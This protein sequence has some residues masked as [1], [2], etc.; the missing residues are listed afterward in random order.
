MSRFLEDQIL[1]YLGNKLQNYNL[2]YEILKDLA[3]KSEGN[4]LYIHY[5][6]KFVVTNSEENKLNALKDLPDFGGEIE[7][8]YRSIW[9][10][11]RGES[12][13]V[14]IISILARIRG[15]ISKSILIK[16]LD[17]DTQLVFDE[18]FNNLKHLLIQK[19]EV[20]IY[21]NSFANFI[22]SVTEHID[23][24]IQRTISDC[25]LANNDKYSIE[26]KLYHLVRSDDIKINQAIRLCNQEF[27]DELALN[28]VNPDLILI[29]VKEVLNK[30]VDLMKVPDIVRILLLIQRLKF[31]NEKVFRQ[32]A[33]EMSKALLEIGKKKESLQYIIREETLIIE[34]DEALYILRRYLQEDE[35][36][37]A[38]I[39]LKAIQNRCI[40]DY[41]NNSIP[42]STIIVDIS[43]TALFPEYDLNKRFNIFAKMLE[44]HCHDD[45]Y[46]IM[47]YISSNV[48]GY[49][50][51]DKNRYLSIKQKE[52]KLGE[53]N[54]ASLG[55]QIKL[56]QSYI[57]Y[58][59]QFYIKDSKTIISAVDD[60][61]KL[62]ERFGVTKN[63]DAALILMKFGTDSRLINVLLGNID[64]CKFEIR[65]GNGV[66][67]NFDS[68]RK[69]FNYYMMKS[70]LA[71]DINK[72]KIIFGE[73]ES[74][75]QSVVE[76]ISAISGLCWKALRENNNELLNNVILKLN[77]VMSEISISL[78][79]RSK[80]NRS[81][82]LPEH[83]IPFVWTEIAVL[84][85]TFN[86]ENIDTLLTFVINNE[87]LG[88]YNEGYRRVL[89]NI[90]DVIINDKLM[91]T[92]SFE[93]LDKLEY[94]TDEFVQNR[95]EKT[96]DYLR[97]IERYGR[98]GAYERARNV[99]IKMLG[100]SM[101]PSWYKEAQMS[102]LGSCIQELFN[103]PNKEDYIINALSNLDYSS[104]EMTFQRYIRDEKENFVGIICEVLGLEVA[105]KYFKLL[106]FPKPKDIL[107][108]V[109]CMS[110]DVLKDGFGY[111]QGTKEI[112]LQDGVLSLINNFKGVSDELIWALTE[113]FIQG[114]DRYFPEYS[115][116]QL[117]TIARSFKSNKI[118]YKE[119]SKRVTRQFVSE[120]DNTRRS[121]YLDEFN[122]NKELEGLE[123]IQSSLTSLNIV[124]E[125]E[126]TVYGRYKDDIDDKTFEGED[127]I[128]KL[129]NQE[130]MMGNLKKAKELIAD[131]LLKF[132]VQGIS[133]FNYSR[134]TNKYLELLKNLVESPYELV[135]LLNNI[136]KNPYGQL[137]WKLVENMLELI[138][139]KLNKEESISVANIITEHFEY[140]L[141]TPESFKKKYEW[142]SSVEKS[143]QDNNST[144]FEF[145]LWLSSLPHG[146]LIKQRVFDVVLWLSNYDSSKY[147]P[148][149]IRNAL[150]AD[151]LEIKE[152]CCGILHN[153][154]QSNKIET[155]CYC[156]YYNDVFKTQILESNN[157]VIL[158]TFYEIFKRANRISLIGIDDFYNTLSSKLFCSDK[159]YNQEGKLTLD[160]EWLGQAKYYLRL[161][162]N[163]V[164]FDSEF[165][166]QLSFKVKNF[167][168]PLT[169]TDIKKVE[170]YIERSYSLPS[171]VSNYYNSIILSGVNELIC[172]YVT[173]SNYNEIVSVLRKYNPKSPE[174]N[175]EKSRPNIFNNVEKI[176]KE[177]IMYYNCCCEYN[178]RLILHFHEAVEN[179]ETNKLD[180]LEIIAFFVNEFDSINVLRS[181]L[182]DEFSVNVD[183][184]E[185]EIGKNQ[186]SKDAI[187]IIIKSELAFVYG[188]MYTPSEVHPNVLASI[189]VGVDDNVQQLT[190]R[191]G[192]VLDVHRFGMPIA[193]GSC[194]L[195]S[196]EALNKVKN[197]RTLMYRITFNEEVL[198]LD[199]DNKCVY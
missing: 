188:S 108:N 104:G 16:M 61:E 23:T 177:N 170:N 54:H 88:I 120:F 92:K 178:G 186:S 44:T 13:Y 68:L 124:H 147:V 18:V 154:S 173:K 71:S 128:L 69:Y 101:G 27:I 162:N 93:L 14:K 163:I 76:S 74:F 196:K 136:F 174:V 21:H 56:I 46:E 19:N 140:L 180:R 169:L 153:L 55:I 84:Y 64:E 132:S 179:R 35:I 109:K 133:I 30:A 43:S 118:L 107:E 195:I 100:T 176:F 12:K 197:N 60:L 131:E 97:I 135:E 110:M 157:F 150:Y 184:Y 17:E 160:C 115:S 3:A 116:L 98:V 24:N 49:A 75:A 6:I 112:D 146:L 50:M 39:L 34:L 182:Y 78:E 144:I 129:V 187:P 47:T 175:L 72:I 121:Y 114:D 172:K 48:L 33:F 85:I 83:L 102:L 181:K 117:K 31:R 142:I 59:K 4:P 65:A 149:L 123:N 158:S 28:N 111:I 151:N 99:Y 103:L 171:G 15:T 94:I 145:V 193:E 167:I 183:P 191:D 143:L 139:S 127:R 79:D 165:L 168:S 130:I 166:N 161:L 57:M 77:E 25:C 125:V 185:L 148:I 10:S 119:L 52:E 9:E 164:E 40:K 8:Y 194:L 89:F 11:I 58:S 2:D 192:R 70:Y 73:W 155:I 189:K 126:F 134:L 87:Q 105:I 41:K 95:W 156:V 42:F 1:I 67:L 152:V 51:W 29:D 36:D 22:I 138:G 5:I 91:S 45:Y 90:S 198:F 62:C 53:I 190:W 96:R 7:N 113:I 32:Y 86:K 122:Y 141:K 66:D 38:K 80:W 82:A 81:Y 199:Y 159:D 26:N 137:E 37:S 106:S 63:D 20:R